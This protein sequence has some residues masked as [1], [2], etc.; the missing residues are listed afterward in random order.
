[1]DARR[2]DTKLAKTPWEQTVIAIHEAKDVMRGRM[3]HTSIV[4]I[5]VIPH[6]SPD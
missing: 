4:R 2:G 6:S 1:M 3:L 5:L